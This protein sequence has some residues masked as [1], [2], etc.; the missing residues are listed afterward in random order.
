VFFRINKFDDD[1]YYIF[2]ACY[3]VI[4]I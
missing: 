1:L 2:A 4:I 3:L